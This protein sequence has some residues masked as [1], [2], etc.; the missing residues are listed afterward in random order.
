MS[1]RANQTDPLKY[2]YK[3]AALTYR[4][5]L[6]FSLLAL[7]IPLSAQAGLPVSSSVPGGIAVIPL[8][9]V[10]SSINPPQ[11]WL[12]DQSVLVTA[13]R[14]LWYAVVGLPLDMQ[15]GTQELRVKIGD[16]V[17]A[18]PFVVVDKDYPEQH[19]TLKDKGKVQL[20]PE[21]ETRAVGEIA[22][23]KKLKLHWREDKNTDLT[24]IMPAKGRMSGNFGLRRFFNG[25]PRSPHAGL[26]LAVARGTPVKASSQGVVLAVDDYFFNG[27]TIFV[28]HGNGLISM[29]C[30][31]DRFSVKAGQTVTKGQKLGLSGMTGRATG[32]HLHWSVILNGAMVDP[33]LF[34][35]AKYQHK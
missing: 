35:P 32:P 33:Q 12:G 28:D 13:D 16:E 24:F 19:I 22:T 23:I 18:Q 8:G 34:L 1:N 14:G 7:A 9:S 26:D 17:K 21:N 11:T 5:C 4:L 10:S 31:L 27:K 2:M 20:S 15:P 3:F 30:H 29:Y 6:H 25:K